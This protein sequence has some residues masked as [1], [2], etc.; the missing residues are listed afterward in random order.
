MSDGQERLHP[1]RWM[2]VSAAVFIGLFFA[3]QLVCESVWDKRINHRLYNCTD[4]VGLG[5]LFPGHW[6][7]RPVAVDHVIIANSMSEP[8]TIKKGWSMLGL[9]CLWVSFLGGSVIISALPAL[10][11]CLCRRR[12]RQTKLNA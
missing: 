10:S 12:T 8:D 1:D 9:W 6:V 11:F 2:L 4:E 3:M 5:Y 7:H